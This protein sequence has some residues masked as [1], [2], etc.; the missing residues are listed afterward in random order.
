MSDS[1][2]GGLDGMEEA[3]EDA[4]LN[5]EWDREEREEHAARMPG[6]YKVAKAAKVGTMIVCPVC[7]KSFKKKSYQQAFCSNKGRG[8]CKDT[9]WNSTD[10]WRAMRARHF[11]K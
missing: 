3:M 5:A 8:N 4:Y 9:Y 2:H 10:E 6:L 7:G 11:N 1:G